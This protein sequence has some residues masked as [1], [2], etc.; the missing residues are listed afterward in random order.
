MADLRLLWVALADQRRGREQ[1]WFEAMPDADVESLGPESAAP[2]I[3]FDHRAPVR[4]LTSRF[5]EAGALA[6]YR[7][8]EGWPTD[9][10]WVAT[11]EPVSLVSEQAQQWSR[12]HRIRHCV[13]TWENDPYQPLY[14]IPPFRQAVRRCLAADLFIAP[15]SSAREHLRIL[16]VPDRRIEVIPPGLDL[17]VFHPAAAPVLEP[18]MIFASPLAR[19]KGIDMLLQALPAVVEAV[20]DARLE[21]LGAGPMAHL[22]R[23]AVAEGLP[24]SYHGSADRG[25]VA[26]RLRHSAVFVTAPTANWKWNEQFGLAYVEAMASGLPIVTTRCGTNHEAVQPPNLLVGRDAAELADALI[27]FLRDPG[28]RARVGDRNL[29]VARERHDLT[30]SAQLLREAL[31]DRS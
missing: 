12:R 15:M 21:V 27:A 6:W 3:P 17:E 8:P 26:E 28:L 19:N 23:A 31:A 5:V 1:S 7:N 11:L 20:P 13:V 16:G 9:V 10:D 29:A 2:E 4:R 18:R 14:R 24:V 25:V 30:R 22:V